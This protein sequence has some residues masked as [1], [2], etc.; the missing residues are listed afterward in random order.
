MDKRRPPAHS[1][2][3]TYAARTDRVSGNPF[4]QDRDSRNDEAE[5]DQTPV[6]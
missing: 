6:R 1:P 4:E 3:R 5:R 2:G